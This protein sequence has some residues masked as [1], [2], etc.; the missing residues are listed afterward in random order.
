VQAAPAMSC[1]SAHTLNMKL[2]TRA[3]THSSVEWRTT[4]I[5][6]YDCSA[7]QVLNNGRRTAKATCGTIAVIRFFHMENEMAKKITRSR[8]WTREE[9]RMLKSLTREKTR[10]VIARKLERSVVAMYGLASKLGVMLGGGRGRKET[11]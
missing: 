9:V 10:M 11:W 3:R 5:S 2:F 1:R 8:P 4:T 6:T 7:P